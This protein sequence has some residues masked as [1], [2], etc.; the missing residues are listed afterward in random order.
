[1]KKN[2]V[3]KISLFIAI[4]FALIKSVTLLHAQHLY[5]ISSNNLSKEIVFQLY[6]QIESSEIAMLSLTK[7]NE[8]RN[9][10]GI[11]IASEKINQI[12]ILNEQTGHHVTITPSVNATAAFQLEPFLIEEL[13]QST[14]GDANRYLVMEAT[15]D[16]SVKSVCAVAAISTTT[17]PQYFYGKKEYVK[18]AL[19]QHRK[20]IG[21]YK[22]KPTYFPAFPDDP[23]NLHNIAQLE[24]DMSYY[25]YMY[26]LP[27]GTLCI[28]DYHFNQ[29]MEGNKHRIGNYLPFDLSGTLNAEQRAATLYSLDL[30]STQ[31]AGSVPVDINVSFVPLEVG[32]LGR[33]FRMQDF[34]DNGTYT[35]YPNTFYPSALW[36][37]LVGYDATWMYD[38]R[39]EM[40]SY[41]SDQF[42][43]GVD[44]NPPSGQRDWVTIMLHE[45][46]HGLGFMSNTT[47]Q[48][49]YIF[50]DDD[51]WA[52]YDEYPCIYT[53]QLYQ[54][55][56][57]PCIT[58][59]SEWEREALLV[60]E[61]LY[62]GRPASNLLAANDGVRVK[63]Y[64]PLTWAGGSSR[65]HWDSSVTFSTFMKYNYQYPLHTFNNRKIGILKDLGWL[66]PDENP[67]IQVTNITGLPSVATIGVSLTL[68]G[69]VVPSNATNQT[70]VWSIQDAG[71]TGASIS[72][73]IFNAAST[74]VATVCATIVNGLAI[75][76]NY[77]KDFTITVSKGSQT[78]PSAPTL[79]NHTTTSITLHT[80]TGCEYRRD[81]G[82]WQTQTIFSGLTPNTSYSFE[83]RK[84]ETATHFASPAGPAALFTTLP[85]TI[86]DS[87]FANLSVYSYQNIVFIKN[88]SDI[89]LKSIQII[90]I[91]GRIVFQNAITN[92]ETAITL[93]VANG[94]YYVRLMSQ[95]DRMIGKKV[96]IENN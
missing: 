93:N 5:S 72:G 92:A 94:L 33:S 56:S 24:E 27:D 37:Q 64:A 53:R 38:I 79:S 60:S 39:I 17:L 28:Y 96:L 51:G 30:W 47:Q 8:N 23:E 36:N 40:N 25:V 43:Y 13:R 15:S 11:S 55:L 77:A 84:E 86:D 20:I 88:E 62:A 63:M 31:L 4:I 6:T 14:L 61:N 80:I 9:V 58:E 29:D 1:M 32:V 81:G 52:Y 26:Q 71:N 65:S 82:S 2:Y 85:L 48:G 50:V 90:D 35:S 73:N 18:E 69:T 66:T 41:Y 3:T 19:P 42:Y 59:L 49:Y 22:Q 75:G 45:A 74:G 89:S 67:L 70:I 91:K 7:N 95:D 87:N 34:F 16:F 21:I 68:S 44:A 57:G 78:A 76:S 54:G 12:I 10:Y 83:A 46:T